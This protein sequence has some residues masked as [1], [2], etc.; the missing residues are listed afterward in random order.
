MSIS[1]LAEQFSEP[2]CGFV[3][4]F[5]LGIA[6]RGIVARFWGVKTRQTELGAPQ[7]RIVSPSTI[8]IRA[9]ATGRAAPEGISKT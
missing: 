3:A 8:S 4:A 5:P 2:R 9:R 7:T 1:P 6:S